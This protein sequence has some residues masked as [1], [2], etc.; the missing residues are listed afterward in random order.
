MYE[1]KN[2]LIAIIG[3]RGYDLVEAEDLEKKRK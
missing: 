1:E 2:I 3:M